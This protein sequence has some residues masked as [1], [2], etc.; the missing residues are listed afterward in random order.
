MGARGPGAKPVKRPAP[1]AIRAAKPSRGRPG[2]QTRAGRLIAW[3]E[4][5][6]VPSGAHAGRKCVVRPWQRDI[7]EAV[8]GTDATGARP[9]RLALLSMA[10]KNGKTGLVAALALAHLCGPE[11]VR[12]GQVLS[13]AADRAQAALV[14]GAMRAMALASPELAARLIFRDFAKTIEDVATGST[15]TAL[16][17]D[18]KKAHGMSPSFWI[19][20]EVAQ[21]RGRDL[22]DALRTGTGAHAEPLGIVISTRS[23]DP[24]NPLEELIQYHEQVRAG[25]VEDGTFRGFVYSAPLDADPWIEETWRAAN[26]ALGDFRSLEDV[27][28]LVAQAKRLPSQESAF[29][30]YVLNQPIAVDDR[31]IGPADWDACAGEPEPSGPCYGGLD[32]SA[33]PADLTALAL[34]WPE[35]GALRVWAFLPAASMETKAREDRAPYQQW[36]AAGHV[37]EMPGRAIDRA[38]LGQWIARQTEGLELHGV[39]SDRWGLEGLK[40]ELE[41]EGIS[42]PL[43]PHGAGFRDVS[44][45]MAAFEARVLDGKL[46][47]GGNP[48]LRWAA[49]N[50]AIEMDPAGNRKLSK[51]RSRG[52][53]DPI[54]AAIY[55]VGLAARQAAPAS[56]EFTGLTL[57]G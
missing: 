3:L 31:W 38:W 9:V 1:G 56:Y 34:F 47:H 35:S 5:L 22:L 21:W 57:A 10:R 43:E 51:L 42:L 23:P 24:D 48:L 14:Y 15:Y 30:A 55:A 13:G 49:A 26:P 54:V 40:V 12:G 33:G 50:S 8:Y 25:I 45:S 39:A 20:D 44:P 7:L 17:S 41:R 2:G 6:I 28:V 16:S 18:A 46:A 29:R 36:R 27:R 37:I 11:A 53:I 32:L 4:T 52:R 19:A